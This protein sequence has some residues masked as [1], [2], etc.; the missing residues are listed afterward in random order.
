[1]K[2]ALS[3]LSCFTYA[4]M[5]PFSWTLQSDQLWGLQYSSVILI[6][7][8]FMIYWVQNGTVSS[9]PVPSLECHVT[10]C[11]QEYDHHDCKTN[12]NYTTV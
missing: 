8:N 11:S 9:C 6:I 1:M 10:L 5:S 7:V 3:F 12:I 2:E 4:C